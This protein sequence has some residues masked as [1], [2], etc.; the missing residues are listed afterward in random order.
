MTQEKLI[1]A[2]SSSTRK[3][4]LESAGVI[5]ET[6]I[7]RIDEEAVK[8]SLLADEQ[9]P[10]NIADALA[11][12]K[13]QKISSKYPEAFVLGA[14]QILVHEGKI[15]SKPCDM[16]AAK[17]QLRSLRNSSHSLISA[18]VIMRDGQTTFRHIDVVKL[19]MRDF[20]DAFLEDY[21]DKEGD[22]ILSCVGA[23]RLEGL[24]SQLFNRVDGDYFAV[25]GLPLLQCLEHFR[26]REIIRV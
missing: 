6:K 26:N 21:L 4:M 17:S 5:F 2:S 3:R 12:M 9:P 7:A 23:Y 10:R 19:A 20:S 14:D 24:G 13:A 11:E 8:L 18:V 15:L 16:E 1:L 25:L 22:E